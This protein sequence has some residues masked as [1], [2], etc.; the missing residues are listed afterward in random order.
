MAEGR[1]DGKS[2]ISA[3]ISFGLIFQT[4]T[5]ALLGSY[6]LDVLNKGDYPT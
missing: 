5:Q 3:W 1:C 4:Q 2:Y 6:F